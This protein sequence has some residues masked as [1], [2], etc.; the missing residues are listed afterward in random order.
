MPSLWNRVPSES[1][2]LSS[3]LQAISLKIAVKKNLTKPIKLF[4][5]LKTQFIKHK[6]STF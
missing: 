6:N 3:M 2:Q 5:G 4:M 1:N